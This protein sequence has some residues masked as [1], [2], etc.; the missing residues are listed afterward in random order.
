MNF[1]N[2]HIDPLLLR[3]ILTTALSLLI[4]LE[5]RIHHWNEPKETLFGTDRT[6]ALLGLS[7]FVFDLLNE[8]VPGI[9][10]AANAG[11][12]FLLGIYY[13]QRTS[14]QK[15]FGATSIIAALIT[16]NLAAVI[17]YYPVWLSVL[18]SVTVILLVE[19]KQELKAFSGRFDNREIVTLV[20][21][22]IISG[23]ILPLLP[24]RIICDLIPV[25]PFK[26][27]LAVVAVSGLSYSSYILKKFFFPQNGIL[28]TSLLGGLY[29]STATTIVLSKQAPKTNQHYRYA[30]GIVW[31]TVMMFLR[32]EIL[33]FIFNPQ[34]ARRL[35]LIILVLILTGTM[36]G[37]IFWQK[38]I[39]E[40]NSNNGIRY[41]NKN[42][43]EFKTALVFA[44]L[45]VIF[46]ALTRFFITH[47]G[48]AGLEVLAAV[49]GLTDIDPFILAI[50]TGH[51]SASTELLLKTT[52]I[53][54]SANNLMKM[55][56]V[57]IFGGKQLGK[58][59][60][61]SFII[62]IALALGMIYFSIGP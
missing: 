48:T 55:I 46:T 11:L 57:Y 40:Q 25:S 5:Q 3:F 35:M 52:V 41:E 22:L 29:S 32:I 1:F 10:I 45:F 21:F 58:L 51:Y 60:A 38:G 7:G 14:I 39:R 37:Y 61:L 31:S 9:H 20:K 43:L 24:D 53:A 50:F 8:K 28:F 54:F 26:F 4:G 19:A 15:K 30:A 44:L 17:H 23:V 6:F 56:Y 33:A 49:T 59:V 12:F 16:F 34:V 62:L 36:T 27:W 2:L 47:Y 42:P 13:L 18:L